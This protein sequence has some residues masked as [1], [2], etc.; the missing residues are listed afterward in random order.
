MPSGREPPSEVAGRFDVYRV[1][2]SGGSSRVGQDLLPH[3]AHA[4]ASRLRSRGAA[5]EVVE[6]A[7]ARRTF[8]L[9]VV[10]GAGI[11]GL[12]VAAA[13]ADDIH[14]GGR[15]PHVAPEES[16]GSDVV[17]CSVHGLA[18]NRRQS[19]GCVRCL[20][21]AR[22]RARH[23]TESG[24]IRR[25]STDAGDAPAPSASSALAGALRVLGVSLA[26][27]FLPAAYYA[28]GPAAE[29]VGRRRAEQARLG[30]RPATVASLAEFD[31]LDAEVSS[32][33]TRA[34]VVTAALWASVAAG[35]AMAYGLAQRRRGG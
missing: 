1:D 4:L 23:L 33:E 31:R 3:A 22:A 24:A 30:D 12:D 15:I 27:G 7:A 13:L 10:D 8:E 5:V 25:P 11:P 14:P 21:Q 34:R 9:E 17:R 32:L 2:S 28:R 6:T 26:I 19:S 29:A 20:A 16:K 18:F 35:A